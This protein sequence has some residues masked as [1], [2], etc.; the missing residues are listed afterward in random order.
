[1]IAIVY[2]SISGNTEDTANMIAREFQLLGVACRVFTVGDTPDLSIY[3]VVLFGSYTW[4]DGSLPVTMRKFLRQIIKIDIQI[5]RSAS[6][7]GTG[8]TIF[9]KYCRAVDEIA[10]HLKNSTVPICADPLK[11][12]QSPRSL[13]QERKITAWVYEIYGGLQ[14]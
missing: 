2:T 5:L 6:V 10:Y 12:E 7:F 14:N 11:I 4:G 1:M 13:G 8:D 9:P 3:D